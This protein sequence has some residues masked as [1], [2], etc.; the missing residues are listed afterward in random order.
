MKQLLIYIIR[1]YKITISPLLEITFGKAC[2]F[3]PTCSEYTI[4]SLKKY[5]AVK[6]LYLGAVRLSKCHS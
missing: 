1:L 3:S 6:G 2:R 5:G 4:G